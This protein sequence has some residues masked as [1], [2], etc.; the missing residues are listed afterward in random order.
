MELKDQVVD[1]SGTAVV[2]FCALGLY[3]WGWL[4]ISLPQYCRVRV[5][6]QSTLLLA[7]ITIMHG[8]THGTSQRYIELMIDVVC[9]QQFSARSHSMLCC[10]RSGI[11]SAA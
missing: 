10:T 7:S 2:S 8:A 3:S 11:E 9:V 4:G 1:L 6:L 5:A